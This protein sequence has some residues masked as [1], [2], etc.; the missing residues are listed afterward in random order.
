[1]WTP[2]AEET[3]DADALVSERRTWLLELCQGVNE[4]HL[5][6]VETIFLVSLLQDAEGPKMSFGFWLL[7]RNFYFKSCEE[8]RRLPSELNIIDV[9][10][11]KVNI[12]CIYIY[13][14]VI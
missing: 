7:V 2:R 1:M 4:R 10:S 5:D 3:C 13:I 14:Y 12:C 9:S 8:C 6:F 11:Y